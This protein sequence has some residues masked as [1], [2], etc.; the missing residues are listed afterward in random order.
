MFLKIIIMMSLSQLLLGSAA[1]IELTDLNFEKE[2]I[3]H[4]LILVEFFA[5]WCGH[6]KKLAPEYASAAIKLKSTSPPVPLANVECTELGQR[7]CQEQGI[8]GYP[9]LKI[10]R[11]GEVSNLIVH[12]SSWY[13]LHYL[14]LS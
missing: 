13:L 6:C 4:D 8:K 9:T 10:F 5:P 14:V 7:V 1:V 12:D 11:N 3:K 2:I